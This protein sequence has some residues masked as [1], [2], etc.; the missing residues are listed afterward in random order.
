MRPDHL[1]ACAQHIDHELGELR[2]RRDEYSDDQWPYA[3]TVAAG[4]AATMW[5]KNHGYRFTGYTTKVAELIDGRTDI[6]TAVAEAVVQ[7]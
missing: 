5:A 7:A 4:I 1:T 2:R 6:G 3:V